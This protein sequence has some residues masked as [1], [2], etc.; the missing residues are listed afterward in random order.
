MSRRKPIDP[1]RLAQI[2]KQLEIKKIKSQQKDI[3]NARITLFAVPIIEILFS[4]I[5]LNTLIESTENVI[6]FFGG[7]YFF[8]TL[9]FIALGIWSKQ[10]PFIAFIIGQVIVGILFLISLPFGLGILDVAKTILFSIF[11]GNGIKSSRKKINIVKKNDI[12]D[13]I[14]L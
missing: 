8:L 2:K 11:L 10:K 3:K 6:W 7:F 4:L 1:H 12:I 5:Y 14:E 13:D 9:L